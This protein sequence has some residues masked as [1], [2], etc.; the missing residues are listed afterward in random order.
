MPVSHRKLLT[1]CGSHGITAAVLQG[2]RLVTAMNGVSVCACV[3]CRHA[4]LNTTRVP[5]HTSSEFHKHSRRTAEVQQQQQRCNTSKPRNAHIH[6]NNACHLPFQHATPLGFQ[7]NYIPKA[8]LV[9]IVCTWTCMYGRKT[10]HCQT[11]CRS[12]LQDLRRDSI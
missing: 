3:L 11:S 5:I 9:L 4:I 12:R 7:A 6:R 10:M 1:L 2:L 8:N